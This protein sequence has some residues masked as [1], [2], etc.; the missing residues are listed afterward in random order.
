MSDIP[1][2]HRH[3]HGQVLFLA[4]LHLDLARPEA[5]ARFEAFCSQGAAG[6]N[7]VY[8]LGDLFDVWVGD[9]DDSELAE[10]AAAALAQLTRRTPTWFMAGNR[11]FLIGADFVT[12]SGVRWLGEPTVIDLFGHRTVVC[13]GDTLCTADHAYQA[14]RRQVRDPVWQAQFL[15]RPL[16]QRRE[17]AAALRE[18]SGQAMA[19]KDEAS[20]DVTD[21]GLAE[22]AA[23]HAPAIII[24]GHTHRPDHHRHRF[25]HGTV[26]RWVL[27]DWY[28]DGD[29]GILV[30][31]AEGIRRADITEA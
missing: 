22:L 14:L 10:R 31:D 19:D 26:E 17:I 20:M 3:R 1:R 8:I 30:A 27:P 21:E 24:H 5:L 12:R 16:A 23:T 7:A 18:D 28:G 15:A 6:A 4:D 13:H 2:A 29:G 11:D 9:D 25:A